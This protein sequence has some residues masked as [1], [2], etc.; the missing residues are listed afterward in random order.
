[1][2]FPRGCASVAVGERLKGSW[3][4]LLGARRDG[5][6]WTLVG[7]STVA[8]PTSVPT[9]RAGGRPVVGASSRE[10]CGSIPRG[11]TTRWSK[12]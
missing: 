9:R 11:L 1:M 12:I 6:S 2:T 10:R 7:A 3:C 8:V 5:W 4:G